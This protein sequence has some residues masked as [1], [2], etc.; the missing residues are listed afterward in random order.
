MEELPR[1]QL[2]A[3]MMGKDFDDLAA[4]KK[5]GVSTVKEDV[6]ISASGAGPQREPSNPSAWI[7]IKARSSALTGLLDLDVPSWSAPYMAP[8][9]RTAASWPLR[10]RS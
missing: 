4:I 3:K 8:I 10:G 6:I 5:E 9:S 1:V 7:Y 2:V